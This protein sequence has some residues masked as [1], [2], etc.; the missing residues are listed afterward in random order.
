MIHLTR[1]N[2]STIVL[3]CDLIEQ[4][5]TT[6]DTVISMTTGQKIMVLESP[7]EVIERVLLFRRSI[8]TPENCDGK[9]GR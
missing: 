7:E 8:L 6:P 9:R 1:L 5:E 4:M 3:N 2:H